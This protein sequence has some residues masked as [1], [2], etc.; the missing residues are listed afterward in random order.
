[1]K[2]LNLKRKLLLS[3]GILIICSV[4]VCS[5]FNYNSKVNEPNTNAVTEYVDSTSYIQGLYKP[6]KI[7]DSSY[8]MAM[9]YPLASE[10]Q[11]DSDLCWIYASLKV[12]ESSLML[13]RGEYH[14][15]S[16][17]GVAYLY[18]LN[19][20]RQSDKDD[21]LKLIDITGNFVNFNILAQ[22]Y[23]LIY[24]NNFSNDIYFD[25]D[26]T[27]YENYSY[28]LDFVD[29][30]IMDTI[31][32][33]NI[34]SDT[35][36][37]S[38]SREEQ[39]Q[40]I[41]EYILTYGGIFAGLERGIISSGMYNRTDEPSYSENDGYISS[42]HAVCLVGWNDE[43]QAFVALNSWGVESNSYSTFFIPYDYAYL[44][45]DIYGYICI[46]ESSAPLTL[47]D[48]SAGGEDGFASKINSAYYDQNNLFL[49]GETLELTYEAKNVSNFD[50]VFINIYKGLENV[51]NEF[52][53][54]FF[55]DTQ[56][57]TISS[58]NLLTLG[59]GYTIKF[60]DIDNL[61][62]F[63]DFYVF[64]GTE[65][66]YVKL[67]KDN[68]VKETDSILFNNNLASG[69]FTQTYYVYNTEN[70]DYTAEFYLP[71]LNGLIKS[72]IDLSVSSIQMLSGDDNGNLIFDDATNVRAVWEQTG[73]VNNLMR[74][75]I[76]NLARNNVGKVILVSVNLSSRI[77]D[78]ES[79]YNLIFL[80]SSEPTISTQYANNIV[81]ELD[82][83]ENS[84]Y[85]ITRYPHF[86]YESEEYNFSYPLSVPTK[87]NSTFIGWYL[88]SDY[89]VEITEI[90]PKI[91]T[92]LGKTPVDP[93]NLES[94]DYYSNLL[95]KLYC[96]DIVIYA[97]WETNE[98]NYFDINLS[99][100]NL[101]DYSGNNS[102]YV[103]GQKIIY[104]NSV[105]LKFDFS[106]V[107]ENLT[108]YRY[109][110]KYEYL[111][112]GEHYAEDYL[113]AQGESLYFT[114]SFKQDNLTCG[115][116]TIS[117][118][119]TMIISHQ[120]SV[121]KEIS[122]N[123][124]ISKKDD[125][126][127]TFDPNSL[128]YTYDKA[129]HSPTVTFNGIYE[130]DLQ[131][132]TFN[133]N[134]EPAINAGTYEFTVQS[135]SNENYAL[136]GDL[137]E[138][139][140]IARKR[141][142]INWL[143]TEKVYNGTYQTPDYE[144]N[145]TINDE[146]VSITFAETGS[147]L[148][149]RMRN[150]G[151]YNVSATNISNS[152]YQFEGNSS[153]TFIVKPAKITITFENI[154]ERFTIAPVNRKKVTYNV[155]GD[156][157]DDISL[158]AITYQTLG[159][160]SNESGEFPIVGRFST[161]NE[162]NSNYDATFIDGTYTILGY[163][164]VFYTLPNGEIYEELVDDGDNPKG[165]TEDIYKLPLFSKFEYDTELVGN[166]ITDLYVKVTIKSYAWIVWFVIII[167][168]F[169]LIYYFAT[170]KS[171]RNKTR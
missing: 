49:Y 125:V 19:I 27:N 140:T 93:D 99:I 143:T 115:N 120:F 102:E 46:D 74:L 171:R 95:N 7:Y 119:V 12:L 104:G 69:T 138:T 9:Y 20:T 15:F 40:V 123:Y 11:T 67:I 152:N 86:E 64:S 157:Y 82:G 24:E 61:I 144:I 128:S 168:G 84:P 131:T 142:T 59:E 47:T 150:V 108:T 110:A 18:Y 94:T 29:S 52:S 118:L 141:I 56:T 28:I 85:N 51:T 167:V 32:P 68:S 129:E 53:I 65:V 149:L 55:D 161:V 122:L 165:I 58:N 135:I 34:H 148:E 103:D 90:S 72:N 38:Y 124:E 146:F 109:I 100:S 60:L 159:E 43:R 77:T 48:S 153:C 145:G 4:F 147:G 16:E 83:G 101:T 133:F 162:Y 127:V 98:L 134:R 121:Y 76:S 36:F 50:N 33:I 80:I 42:S 31:R 45:S 1:M 92:L 169:L 130:E 54:E 10:N 89:T 97:R 156:L 79:T 163:Y 35:T 2:K 136:S 23:G 88:D 87:Y 107:L 164:Y 126:T 160:T 8:N 139:L 155:T 25:I 44:Y 166:G 62:A 71:G 111:F 137:T 154:T 170:K 113:S 73:T 132:L 66:S 57:I 3:L 78:A 37:L 158:L 5:L 75:R 41:K 30:T 70:A 116:Y 21:E 91:S 14:N 22:N 96:D 13:Q 17:I 81:Y 114:N 112:N 26:E 6:N 105:T 106:P 39:I 63:K 151:S 117:V